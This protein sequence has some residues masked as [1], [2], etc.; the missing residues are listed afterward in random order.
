MMTPLLSVNQLR[1]SF[2][3]DGEEIPVVEGVDLDLYPGEVVGLVGE[4][5]S[6]KSVTSL[7]IMQLL[8]DTPGRITG[9]SISYQ[10]Q[11]LRT[12]SQKEMRKI[13]GNE[14]SMIFQEPMTSLNP[15]MTIEKQLVEAIKEHMDYTKKAAK[16]HAMAMLEQ[17]GIPRVKE[18]MKDY[19][20]QL[21]GG[22]RQRVMIAMAL[23]CEPKL[24]IADEPTTAL[25]VT[26]QA[27]ILDVMRRLSEEKQTSILFITHDLGVIAEMCD[28][29]AVMYAGRIVEQGDVYEIFEQPKHPYTKG[30][31]RSIPRLGTRMSRLQSIEGQVPSIEERPKGCKFA[32]RCPVAEAQCFEEEPPLFDGKNRCWLHNREEER[33]EQT[34]T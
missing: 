7:S 1:T 17:V 12:A 21:S 33:H 13:R 24:L 23:A 2:Y 4:S 34:V 29:V 14:L 26:I 27:Q 15:V 32:N 25:D 6:G 20:H 8:Q 18:V 16:Q 28:R 11:E 19:P 5:G 3:A 9:G 30:L 22:M 31:L 10:E